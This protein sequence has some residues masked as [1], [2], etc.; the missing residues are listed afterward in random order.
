[1]PRRT[2]NTPGVILCHPQPASSD[3]NDTLT[4][5]LARRLADAGMLALRFNFRGVA[6]SQ[7]QQTDG[8]LEPLDLAGATDTIVKIPGVNP[9]KVCVIGHGFGAYIALLYAPFDPRIRTVVAISLP[10]FRAANGFPRLFERPKLFVTG[11][12]DE[13]CPR[14]KLEPFVE[15]QAGPKGLKVITGARHLMRGYEEAT[16]TT[17]IKYVTTW[18]T[19]PGV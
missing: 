17:I 9:A 1:M 3:M 18:A 8:R 4:A 7:G 6:K 11:E 16:V 14:Y 19:M 12:F 15:Q 2:E 13:I 5:V 10:L